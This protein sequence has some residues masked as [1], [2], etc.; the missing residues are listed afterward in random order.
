MEKR[1]A[2]TKDGKMTYCTASE[3][4]IGKGRCNHIAHQ[5]NNES[6]EDFCKRVENSKI[7]EIDKIKNLK[8]DD[9]IE[10]IRSENVDNE[11]LD[12]LVN[13]KDWFV[14]R[15]VARQGYGLDKLVN[16]EN[17]DVRVAV[18]EQGYGLDKLVNDKDIDVRVA[19]AEQGY[20]LDKLVNDK[21]SEV[22][23]AVAGKGYGLDKLINDKD[24]FVRA[25][26]AKYGRN[27][28]LDILINDENYYVIDTVINNDNFK[29]DKRLAN[30]TGRV[31]MIKEGCS[32]KEM[33]IIRKDPYMSDEIK[34]ALIEKGVDAEKLLK[35]KN[36][37][38]REAAIRKMAK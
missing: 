38:V 35:D 37:I 17:W 31:E 30:D 20:G 22:R 23:A 9:K 32:E 34:L 6:A 14:R 24:E 8:T 7:S 4:N 26:V 1:L 25:A 21:N 13:D 2:L 36:E 12:V 28:D 10:L 18:A 15:D 11:I 3:E 29:Y 27:K 16:D 19:V 5:K 33:D